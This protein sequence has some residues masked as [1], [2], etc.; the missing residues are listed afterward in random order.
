[1]KFF[2]KQFP[3][4]VEKKSSKLWILGSGKFRIGILKYYGYT[5]HLQYSTSILYVYE[6]LCS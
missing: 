1:M 5:V 3:K 4:G 6:I 2:A